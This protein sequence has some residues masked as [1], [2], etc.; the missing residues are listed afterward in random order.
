MFH[1]VRVLKKPTNVLT[2]IFFRVVHEN[3]G[4]LSTPLN[5]VRPGVSVFSPSVRNLGV[6]FGTRTL[7][8]QEEETTT[9]V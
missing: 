4:K 8:T 5:R 3:L 9:R 2:W 7:V 6:G 1:S